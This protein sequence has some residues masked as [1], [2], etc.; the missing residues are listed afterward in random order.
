MPD[1]ISLRCPHCGSSGTLMLNILGTFT[2]QYL[3]VDLVCLS[4]KEHTMLLI[5]TSEPGTATLGPVDLLPPA[6]EPPT[7]QQLLAQAMELQVQA[8]A[9]LEQQQAAPALPPAEALPVVLTDDEPEL[10]TAPEPLPDTWQQQWGEPLRWW[11][12][13]SGFNV[14]CEVC[15]GPCTK[16]EQVRY[17]PADRS[18]SG[19]G[20]T[21]HRGCWAQASG[22]DV[23]R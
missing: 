23:D 3:D 11:K 13:T 18:P 12:Y 5:D 20:Q 17:L 1:T 10:T 7:A 8:Q 15:G 6:P 16:G 2:N 22:L 14:P 4:C 19:T 21:M 9:L